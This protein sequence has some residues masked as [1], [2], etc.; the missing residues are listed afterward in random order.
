[1]A[2]SNTINM[3]P[4]DE[5]SIPCY[6]ENDEFEPTPDELDIMYQKLSAG[7]II[8]LDWKCSGRRQPT[9]TNIT[10]TDAKDDSNAET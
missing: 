4:S 3:T 7:E 6:G 2:E 8:E 10:D 5:W 1:M 9:P